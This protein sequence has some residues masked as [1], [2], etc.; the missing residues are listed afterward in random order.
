MHTVK[1]ANF[2][3]NISNKYTYCFYAGTF[4]K[5]YKLRR[6]GEESELAANFH[7]NDHREIT[8]SKINEM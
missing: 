8:K 1:F 2:C 3:S 5:T 6:F 7:P 4:M